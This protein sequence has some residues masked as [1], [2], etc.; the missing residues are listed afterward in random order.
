MA[1]QS[2][3]EYLQDSAKAVSDVL[4]KF[5]IT[6]TVDGVKLLHFEPAQFLGADQRLYYLSTFCAEQLSQVEPELFIFD[7]SGYD[8]RG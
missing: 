7:R 2:K 4:L 5:F 1:L 6:M 3:A 8:L